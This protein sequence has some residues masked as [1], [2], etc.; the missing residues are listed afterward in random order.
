M[1][2]A[3]ITIRLRQF[4]GGERAIIVPARG[5]LMNAAT[6]AGV[7]EIAADCGGCMTCA[8]CHVYVDAA[9]ASRLAPPAADETAML[10]LAAAATR[11]TSRLSC[12]IELAPEL[13]GLVV[14]LPERQY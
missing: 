13:D 11:A 9:W 3:N 6:R 4:G 1:A 10:E 8:T 2:V 12:Q 14:E 7:D 5:S